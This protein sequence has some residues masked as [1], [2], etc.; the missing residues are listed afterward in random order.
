[1]YKKLQP[2]CRLLLH[3]CHHST[4]FFIRTMT[5]YTL[6]QE[7]YTSPL[8]IIVR[9]QNTRQQ[10][11]LW[12]QDL[13]DLCLYRL[14]NRR[15]RQNTLQYTPQ[16]QNVSPEH[17]IHFNAVQNRKCTP[18]QNTLQ[19]TKCTPE[20]KMH[21]RTQNTLQY[22]QEYKIH[23]NTQKLYSNTLQNAIYAQIH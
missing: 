8:F 4:I 12:W 2:R 3:M 6:I 20:Q 14:E 7:Q 19:N 23:S 13:L 17:K 5:V 16:T 18:E 21:S 10:R 22:T 15:H 1:M 11:T 9:S